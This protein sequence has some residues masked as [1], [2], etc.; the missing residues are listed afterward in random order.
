MLQTWSTLNNVIVSYCHNFLIMGTTIK[1]CWSLRTPFDIVLNALFNY[2]YDPKRPL[3]KTS[4]LQM[5][6]YLGSQE[7]PR[8]HFECIR[9]EISKVKEWDTSQDLQ[10]ANTNSKNLPNWKNCITKWGPRP[11]AR[12]GSPEGGSTLWVP[13]WDLKVVISRA[14]RVSQSENL[15][16]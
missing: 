9:R 13:T 5:C 12:A 3:L 16:R 4:V 1:L 8:H 6:S 15:T 10:T 7:V 11:S 2:G 14:A